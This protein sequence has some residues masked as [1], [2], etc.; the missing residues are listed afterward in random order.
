MRPIIGSI[1][2]F[3]FILG[4]LVVNLWKLLSTL[5]WFFDVASVTTVTK[6]FKYTVSF[7]ILTFEEFF[8]LLHSALI[9][10]LAGALG[11]FHIL[12]SC[13]N[14]SPIGFTTEKWKCGQFN[15]TICFISW[16]L[17]LTYMLLVH[18][19]LPY[20]QLYV[21]VCVCVSKLCTCGMNAFFFLLGFFISG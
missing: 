5:N 11:I 13:C 18:L 10:L 14:S 6:F 8:F 4:M 20:Y 17:F 7:G 1:F 9:I 15:R 3:S 2:H 21:C 16:V 12:G 19:Y